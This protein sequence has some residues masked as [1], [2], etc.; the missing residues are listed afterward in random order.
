MHKTSNL[1]WLDKKIQSIISQIAPWN[2]KTKG[3]LSCDQPARQQAG[4]REVTSLNAEEF[5]SFCLFIV[6]VGIARVN[7]GLIRAEI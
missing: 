5:K 7:V 3:I 1:R 2:A 6:T 4:H